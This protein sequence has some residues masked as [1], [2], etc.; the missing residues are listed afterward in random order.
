[1]KRLLQAILI[2]MVVI[3]SVGCQ[4]YYYKRNIEEYESRIRQK[5]IQIIELNSKVS[6]LS[7]TV[8]TYDDNRKFVCDKI[9]VGI[10]SN[11]N[12]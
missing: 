4:K 3:A 9:G 12:N 7:K 5:N 1:M 10:I 6:S 2:L 8:L 11:K